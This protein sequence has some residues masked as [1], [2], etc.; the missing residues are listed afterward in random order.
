MKSL[1]S[2]RGYKPCAIRTCP[3][4]ADEKFRLI[5]LGPS[6]GKTMHFCSNV[7]KEKFEETA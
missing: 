1:A 5:I 3:N 6:G 4:K 2:N 7:C